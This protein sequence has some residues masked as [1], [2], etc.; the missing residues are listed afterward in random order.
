MKR[1]GSFNWHLSKWRSGQ[2]AHLGI[3][4]ELALRLDLTV[5]LDHD[6]LGKGGLICVV[7]FG[8]GGDFVAGFMQ[9]YRGSRAMR[10][11]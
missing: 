6:R 8:G 2:E 1:D 3:L 11:E 4:D 7:V 10:A 9:S 5:C